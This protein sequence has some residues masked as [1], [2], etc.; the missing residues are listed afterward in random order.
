MPDLTMEFTD[1]L[2][3]VTCWC[4]INHAV[5]ENL[6]SFQERQHRDGKNVMSIYCPLGHEHRPAGE[7]KAARLARELEEEKDRRARIAA[8]RDRERARADENERRRIAQKAATTRLGKR[9]KA[10]TCPCCN[11]TF[12]QLARHM[13]NQHPEF[14]PAA[15]A[16]D[17]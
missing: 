15:E 13:A 10:G 5:P 8:A 7:G 3:V 11:R 4:G 14:D 6:R 1:R 12:K 2:T 17:A 16:V 9:A